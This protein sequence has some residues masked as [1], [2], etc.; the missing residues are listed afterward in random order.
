M[1]ADLERY[2]RHVD[3]SAGPDGCHPWRLAPNAKGYGLFSVGGRRGS[4]PEAHRW[5]YLNGTGT[6]SK[7][8]LLGPLPAGICVCH[9]CDTPLCQNQRH[10]FRGTRSDNMSDCAKKGRI[11]GG[12]PSGDRSPFAKVTDVQVAEIRARYGK[13]GITQRELAEEFGLGQ[14]YVS[15][16][17][18]RVRRAA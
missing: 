15:D 11:R 1:K 4:R 10:W 16:L 7:G 18:R 6:D 17:V 13:G 2:E 12:N 3:R 5:G 9:T 8:E 14:A